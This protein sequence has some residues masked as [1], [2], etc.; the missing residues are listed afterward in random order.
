MTHEELTQ[1]HLNLFS[2]FDKDELTKDVQELKELTEPDFLETGLILLCQYAN[3]TTKDYFSILWYAFKKWEPFFETKVADLKDEEL[4]TYVSQFSAHYQTYMK[5]WIT[6]IRRYHSSGSSRNLSFLENTRCSLDTQLTKESSLQE[7]F[8]LW[9]SQHQSEYTTNYIQD[10]LLASYEALETLHEKPFEKITKEEVDAINYYLSSYLSQHISELMHI[11][12][13]WMISLGL[14]E[15]RKWKVVTKPSQEK[16]RQEEKKIRRE[17]MKILY[18]HQED[19]KACVAITFLETKIK[20]KDLLSLKPDYVK[21]DVL[22][23]DHNWILFPKDAHEAIVK[24]THLIEG[25]KQRELDLPKQRK[26]LE[27]LFRKGCRKYLPIPL[28]TSM[29]GKITVEPAY[30]T[31]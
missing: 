30:V 7:V 19:D 10:A 12:E 2:Q 5:R 29:L 24:T 23:L 17:E 3:S 22:L 20:T 8:T 4:N 14:R 18:D 15:E 21:E 31:V 26:N 13:E 6:W 9:F 11:L 1:K 27:K 28:T 25:W 16:H